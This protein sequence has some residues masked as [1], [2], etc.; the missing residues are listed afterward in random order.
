MAL[1]WLAAAW[2]AG[3]AYAALA[4]R[5]PGL[6]AATV[7]AGGC[8]LALLRRS[9]RAALAGGLCAAATWGGAWRYEDTAAAPPRHDSIAYLNG[10]RSVVLRGVVRDEPVER[11][12]AQ[13][14]RIEA[15]EVLGL[16]G[17]RPA[18]GRALVRV[19]IFPRFA[20][21][22]AV[23]LQGELEVPPVLEGFDYRAY[24]LRQGVVSVIDFPRVLKVE[25]GQGGAALR[26]VAAVRRWLARGIERTLPE[27]E[28][29]LAEGFLLG[30]RDELPP[31]LADAF[32]DTGT[33]HLIAIS[34]YNVT[35]VI[36]LT[37]GALAWLIGRRPAG[38][39]ALAVIA[40]YAALTGASPSVVRAAVMGGLYVTAGLLGRPASAA[41]AIAASAAGM[42]G[43][44]PSVIHDAS[45][46]LSFAA[47]MALAWLAPPLER[48][49]WAAGRKMLF[50]S[51]ALRA[52]LIEPV[53][54]TT[55]AT[56]ATAPLIALHFQRLSL[57]S[58]PANVFVLPLFPLALGA[59]FVAA[60][61][62]LIPGAA[63]ML[64]WPTWLTLR[65]VTFSVETLARLPGAAVELTGFGPLHAAAVLACGSG[66]TW[67]L[68]SR[69]ATED[70]GEGPGMGAVLGRLAG[71]VFRPAPSP[72]ASG[73]LAAA[74]VALGW[75]ALV[76]HGTAVLTLTALDVGQGDA[77]LIQTPSGF[78]ALID[79]GP[80][81]AVL[82]ELGRVLG[83]GDRSIDLV[84]L[85][86][87]QADH[88]AGL[89][90]TL[91]R[92]RVGSVV[93]G[94]GRSSAGAAQAWLQ[95]M[96][97]EGADVR[98]L[99]APA[100]IALGDA[101][102]EVLWPPP[103]AGGENL[104]RASL[105]L[106]LRYEGV[107]ML[108]TG[109]IEAETEG[110]LVASKLDLRADVLKVAH[111]GS[112]TSTTQPWLDAVRPDVAVISVGEGNRFGH[113]APEVV[114]RL[115][116]SGARVYRTDANGRIT[117]ATDGE[118]LWVR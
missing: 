8:A 96:R 101:Q 23:E 65:A 29:A 2:L 107:T 6:V 46:Q 61:G 57:V 70:A 20:Y 76:P 63:P 89:V 79:G 117:I 27:P 32:N 16:N 98:R 53:T 24:L 78:Q 66:A 97:A 85:T 40:G 118:R 103:G 64:A 9:P 13:R 35:L 68:A 113:P 42:A 92:Y 105:V 31:S 48:K 12:G 110:D 114:E 47:T 71:R 52:F 10:G 11:G 41:P 18:S 86:H 55:A 80:D 14:F 38:F 95:A 72:W 1:V 108:L 26:A 104:N 56:L 69:R 5:D 99:T 102:L 54:A 43:A 37:V 67:W 49:V 88:V 44:E 28:A 51:E 83:P 115:E 73:A 34:G 39:A 7:A 109:D 45:Y 19:P 100:T 15:A 94:P 3:T 21:G 33:S 4:G 106:R 59:S 30:R 81:G 62:G 112:R 36:G 77:L 91:Q 74:V 25:P 58:I 90:K 50:G 17:W 60:V 75:N 84:V 87:P 22:D 111:H 82:R 116:A 93:F